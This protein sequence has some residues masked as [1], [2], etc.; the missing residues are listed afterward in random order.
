MKGHTEMKTFMK[1]VCAVAML[2]AFTVS[3]QELQRPTRQ[4]LLGYSGG[5]LVPGSST[6]NIPAAYAPIFPFPQNGLGIA[7]RIVGT[8]AATTTNCTIILEQVIVADNIVQAADSTV[9]TI[10]I[11][12]QQNGTTPVDYFTNIVSSTAN[13]PNSILRVRS[14][15]NTNLASIWITN[16]VAQ[17]LQ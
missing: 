15:Q 11:S 4:S 17:A 9:N 1:I 16:A 5:F 12:A 10:T 2:S 6:T 14:I 3:S 8:N 7:L 13:M